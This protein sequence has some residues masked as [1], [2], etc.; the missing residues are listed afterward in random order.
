MKDVLN[1]INS[2]LWGGFTVGLILLCGLYLT[3]K[4]GFIQLRFVKG[5]RLGGRGTMKAVTSAL[6]ASLG[7]G[8]ITGCAAAIAAGGTGSVFWMWISALLGMAISYTEN[9]IGIAY[10]VK[11]G[12]NG[13]MTYIEKGLKC[14]QM[15]FI[16]ASGCVGAALTMGDAA[17]SNAFAVALSSVAADRTGLSEKKALIIISLILAAIT[18]IIVFGGSVSSVMSLTEKIVPFMGALYLGAAIVILAGARLNIPAALCGI[19]REAF[20]VKAFGGGVL[21]S[22]ISIGLRRGVFSNEAGMGSSVLVHAHGGFTSPEAAGSWACFEVFLDTI[23]CCTVTAL[24]VIA[25]GETDITAAFSSGFAA[26]GAKSA[27]VLLITLSVC[28][29]AYASVLGWFCYGEICASYIIRK[30]T[31]KPAVI[32]TAGYIFRAAYA[33]FVFIGGITPVDTAFAAADIFNAFIMLPNML[34]I[35]FLSITHRDT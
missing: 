21:G 6:A 19:V 23:V 11:Y 12:G 28:L 32:K 29:F 33:A 22:A 2:V 10:I 8:N 5:L 20:S 27:G 7:T 26:V 18:A 4:S 34:C 35:V 1:D 3:V 31:K 16:Y 14:K 15:A 13:P 9:R 17:Q 24:A 30:L 25:T